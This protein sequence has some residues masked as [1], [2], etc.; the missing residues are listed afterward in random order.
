MKNFSFI[1]LGNRYGAGRM[2]TFYLAEE[3]SK[4]LRLPEL[5]AARIAVLPF[6]DLESFSHT[7]P[8]GQY[9][10]EQLIFELSEQGFNVVDIRNSQS[11][12]SVREW[13]EA[14][15]SRGNGFSD[16]AAKQRDIEALKMDVG[17]DLVG[18][19]CGTYFRAKK[20]SGD[21]PD[22]DSLYY[23]NLRMITLPDSL[24]VSNASAEVA[25]PGSLEKVKKYHSIK[26]V[27]IQQKGFN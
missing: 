2:K 3:L 21:N 25:I 11:I 24:V 15:L 6:T 19:V 4:N 10:S 7:T 12:Y 20:A 26:S 8:F 9:M 16:D 17:N 14:F 5:R 23:I 22:N 1:D 13:G 18:L 27:S